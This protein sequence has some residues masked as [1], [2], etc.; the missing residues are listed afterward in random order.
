MH[1]EQLPRVVGRECRAADHRDREFDPRYVTHGGGNGLREETVR[2][3][4]D[5]ERRA[6]SHVVDDV[7]EGSQHRPVDQIDRAD[8]CHATRERNHGEAERPIAPAQEAK[9]EPDRRGSAAGQLA[10]G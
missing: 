7:V 10:H 8:E 6:P 2:T 5:L 9:R 4:A 3:R 1:G